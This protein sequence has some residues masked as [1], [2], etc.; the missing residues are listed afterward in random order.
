MTRGKAAVSMD[1]NHH[2]KNVSEEDRELFQ[3]AV[4]K[5]RPIQHDKVL[6]QKKRSLTPKQHLDEPPSQLLPLSDHSSEA[7]VGAEQPLFFARPG[8]SAKQIKQLKQGKIPFL[9]TLDLHGYPVEQARSELLA[10]LGH[11]YQNNTR[12]IL[13]IHGK[14][15]RDKPVLKNKLNIWLKQISWVLAFGTAQPRHGGTGA[16]YVLLRA[17]SK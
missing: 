6:L 16:T 2:N 11:A 10:F 17:A 7:E 12:S 8:L 5:V 3:T 4:K 15:H 9:A 1:K 14:G 13:I